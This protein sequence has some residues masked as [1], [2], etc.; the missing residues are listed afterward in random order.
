MEKPKKK[1]IAKIV[2][3]ILF[4]L[5]GALI[6]VLG[7][8]AYFYNFVLTP[9]K[10]TSIVKQVADDT[11]DADVELGNVYLT[12]FASFP[13]LVVAVDSSQV[14]SRRHRVDSSR[15][16]A[17]RR[18]FANRR[19]TSRR[20]MNRSDGRKILAF[21]KAYI[22][23]NPFEYLFNNK[24]KA[25][26]ISL[27]EPEFYYT[28][29]ADSTTNFDIIKVREGESSEEDTEIPKVDVKLLSVT[30]GRMRFRD[31]TSQ[32]SFFLKDFDVELS[33]RNVEEEALLKGKAVVPRYSMEIFGYRFERNRD[34]N[35]N[36]DGR[37]DKNE[38][39]FLLDNTVLGIN[40]V[41][42]MA[43]GNMR[44]EGEGRINIDID[45]SMESPTLDKL[46]A[47][48]PRG[49]LDENIKLNSDG[50]IDISGKLQGFYGEGEYPVY[51][52]YVR[53]NHVRAR[54]GDM[55]MGIDELSME[56]DMV[57]D[58]NENGRSF[59]NLNRFV[60][61]AGDKSVQINATGAVDNFLDDPSVIADFKGDIDFSRLNMIFPISDSISL[62]GT[63][64]F[65]LYTGFDVQNVLDGK[66]NHVKLKGNVLCNGI[67]FVQFADETGRDST[68]MRNIINISSLDIDV[69]NGDV[70][71]RSFLTAEAAR[72][73]ISLERYSEIR[74]SGLKASVSGLNTKNGV[75]EGLE[76]GVDAKALWY[77]DK[78]RK[79]FRVSTAAVKGSGSSNADTPVPNLNLDVN[80][81]SL[82][83]VI[84]DTLNASGKASALKVEIKPQYDSRNRV[85]IAL[86]GSINGLAV[87]SR[88]TDTNI[89]VGNTNFNAGLITPRKGTNMWVYEGTG[90][91]ET[92]T[93]RTGMFPLDI[94]IPR[95]YFTFNT[96]NVQ[97]TRTSLYLGKS[98]FI[99]SGKVKGLLSRLLFDRGLMDGSMYVSSKRL[100]LN[101][102]MAAAENLTEEE[103]LS[104]TVTSSMIVIPDY[105][106]R[107]ELRTNLRNVSLFDLNLDNV[108]GTITVGNKTAVLEPL[109]IKTLGANI[110]IFAKYRA[111]DSTRAKIGMEAKV[112]SMG[113]DK[114]T[115]ILPSLGTMLPMMSSMKGNIDLDMVA[116]GDL[117]GDYEFDMN[118]LNAV[119]RLHGTDLVL[120]DGDTFAK[121]S[122]IL[123][124]K[125]K[126]EN[127]LPKLDINI[128]AGGGKAE[129]KPARVNMDRYELIAGG[130]QWFDMRCDYN[131][132]VL[133]SPL[134]FKAG[135]D[136][137]NKGDELKIGIG[138][139]SLKKTDFGKVEKEVG[140]DYERLL[141]SI[142]Q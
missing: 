15:L 140:A 73:Y 11:V 53:M 112:K 7:A 95:S 69:D 91:I 9:E 114:F 110:N 8:S 77:R 59:L 121:I 89:S 129:I 67:D 68:D 14:I 16:E 93:G 46:M 82:T 65:D 18:Y 43:D 85:N 124:F 107:L 115:E 139:A 74:L 130:T 48:V 105:I 51:T 61:E 135:V 13:R 22:D 90:N 101:E 20:N 26:K 52:S 2:R 49:V 100:D 23:I 34:L 38:K 76:V 17:R 58:M 71:K 5:A 40:G 97:L 30:K 132:S 10:L 55:P 106:T 36:I 31:M 122:K 84:P 83:F 125:N 88:V 1:K 60:L 42:L 80:V 120:M 119:V 62:A 25:D 19:D 99:L 137:E 103:V 28:I 33:V 79:Y 50:K 136:I 78:D 108:D 27:I 29:Y 96:R 66:Y 138:K 118:T 12:V 128:V 104:D 117:Y 47:F 4:S 63:G 54:Y 81:A 41:N 6:L 86:D 126:K 37:Y 3:I 35:L 87:K 131:V 109:E 70:G 94:R 123:M 45:L 39:V 111:I 75:Y 21:K 134:P 57:I 72:S 127:L 116:S 44:S 56:A 24:I 64:K 32:T 142:K 92:M 141:N 113:L 133:R 102:I 98:D